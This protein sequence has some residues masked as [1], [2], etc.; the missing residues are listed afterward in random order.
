MVSVWS[1]PIPSE[2]TGNIAGVH[3][4]HPK[5]MLS[6]WLW[7]YTDAHL[8]PGRRLA[9]FWTNAA[10]LSIEHL[11]KKFCEILIEIHAFSFKVLR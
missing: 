10:M 8:S 2:E 7:R 6:T 5:L 3:S 9:S 11:G 4:S 1:W